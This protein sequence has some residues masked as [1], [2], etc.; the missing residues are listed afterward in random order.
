MEDSQKKERDI[1]L[2]GSILVA[3]L[4]VAG[5]LVYSV[6]ARNA[7]PAPVNSVIGASADDLIDDDVILG[8]PSAPVTVVEFGDYQCPY[9]GR[10][11]TE[12]ESK[13]RNE[14]IKSGKVKMVYRDFAFLSEESFSAAMASQCAAEQK[15]FWEYHDGLFSAEV[16][17]GREHNGNL[18]DAFFKALA[19]SLGLDR[20]RFDSC[21]SSKKYEKE[22]SN[23]YNDGLAAGV[24]G[25]PTTFIGGQALS[26]A[27][28]YASVAE[29]IEQAL[30]A[31]R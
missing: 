12:V 30:K 20:N 22:I 11:F 17:D 27:P 25:T 6:G 23:D 29:A 9:C 26:G 14:Y 16:I 4:L 1:L 21:L 5:A 2:P 10:F 3:A 24:T 13:L 19:S 15:K 28:G 7:P 18:S 8:D 31:T